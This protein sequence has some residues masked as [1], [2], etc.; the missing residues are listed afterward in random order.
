MSA[1]AAPQPDP[2]AE[3]HQ[4]HRHDEIRCFMCL[5]IYTLIVLSL[6]L[7]VFVTSIQ[8]VKESHTR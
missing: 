2:A 8:S 6:S 3:F 7:S 4:T 1:S 5:D